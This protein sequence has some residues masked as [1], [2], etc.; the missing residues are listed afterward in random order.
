[1]NWLVTLGNTVKENKLKALELALLGLMVLALPSLEAPKNIFLVFYVVVALFRQICNKS[2][3]WEFWDWLFLLWISSALLSTVFAGISPGNEWKGFIMIAK[4]VSVGWL[5][6]RANYS[7]A[8]LSCLFGVA[9]AAVVPSLI[10][11]YYKYSWLHTK[12]SLEL[13][14]VGH[15]NHSAIFITIMFGASVGACLSL[16][17]SASIKLRIVLL[18]LTSFLFWSLVVGQ[19]RGAFGVGILLA[20]ALIATLSIQGR[21]KWLAT[22]MVAIMVLM[23]VLFNTA[24][25][26]KQVENQ[27]KNIILSYRDKVWNISLEAS[28]FYP[29]FGVGLKNWGLVKP[30]DIKKSVESRHQTYNPK[31]YYF[32]GYSHNIYLSTL[33][34][35]GYVGLCALLLLMFAWI[36]HLVKSHTLTRDSPV[37]AYLWAGSFSAWL[38]SFGIGFVNNTIDQEHGILAFMFLGLYLSY[39][40]QYAPA[41]KQTI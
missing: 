6:A 8:Q 36:A 28:R 40:R 30:I 24:I 10:W 33:V 14:S 7:V 21:V 23:S 38:V 26:K 18:A 11:G 25:V 35:Q 31:D 39:V 2:T 15:V 9:L 13:P 19:S 34:E 41:N 4:Y 1:M 12:H 27:Q 5:I 16:W 37:A 29:L 22:A 3:S 20:I 17:Q 32:A